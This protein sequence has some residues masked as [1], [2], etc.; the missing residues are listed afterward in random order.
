MDKRCD[1]C[2]LLGFI[3]LSFLN[4]DC[5]LCSLN[6]QLQQTRDEFAQ[7]YQKS[8]QQSDKLAER[9]WG[10]ENAT[11]RKHYYKGTC[12]LTKFVLENMVRGGY[13]C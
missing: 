7:K 6:P 10:L 8:M 5:N 2:G 13:I 9:Y 11:P 12:K 1:G 3:G 4:S